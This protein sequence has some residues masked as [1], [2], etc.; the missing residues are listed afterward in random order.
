M[1]T[2][3]PATRK[4]TFGTSG[5]KSLVRGPAYSFYIREHARWAKAWGDFQSL[6]PIIEA[7]RDEADALRRLPDVVARA[8][9]ERDRKSS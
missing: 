3:G 7:A 5:W 8:F 6:R 1:R 4:P 9:V 2:Y